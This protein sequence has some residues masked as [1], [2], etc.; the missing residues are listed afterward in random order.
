MS[1]P[2]ELSIV[3]EIRQNILS[4]FHAPG[5]RLVEAQLTERYAAG[6]AAVRLAL[7]ELDKE[8]LVERSANRGATVRRITIAEA[9]EITEARAEVEAIIARYAAVRADEDEK[10]ELVGVID[11]MRSAVARSDSQEYSDLNRTFHKRLREIS[12][13]TVAIELVENLRNRA[14][15]QQYRIS[16]IPG[17]TGESLPEHEAIVDAVVAADPDGAANAMRAHLQSVIKVLQSWA[18]AGL[19]T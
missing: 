6:R 10:R 3:D 5:E 11:K 12:K 4:G 1:D 18:A 15:A 17:R 8:G 16:L 7:L 19:R 2:S 9:I 13:H 14:S